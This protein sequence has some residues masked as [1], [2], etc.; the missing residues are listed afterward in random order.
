MRM[1][2]IGNHEL[3][4]ESVGKVRLMYAGEGFAENWAL[5]GE[6]EVDYWIGNRK[7]NTFGVVWIG[8]AKPGMGEERENDVGILFSSNSDEAMESLTRCRESVMGWVTIEFSKLKLNS[9]KTVNA[10]C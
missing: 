7:L 2:R 6:M 10:G 3:V 9:E 1:L 5:Q 4:G 8:V